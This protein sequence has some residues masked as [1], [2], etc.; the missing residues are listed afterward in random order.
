MVKCAGPVQ[1][2]AGAIHVRVRRQA[3]L[4]IFIILFIPTSQLSFIVGRD[5]ES[6]MRMKMMRIASFS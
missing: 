2:R 1:R 6:Q 4:F 5:E 3:I